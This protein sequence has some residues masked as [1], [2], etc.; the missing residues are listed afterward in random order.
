MVVSAVEIISLS[1]TRGS[2]K[3]KI[4]NQGS[5]DHLFLMP[6]ELLWLSVSHLVKP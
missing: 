2:K 6:E 5:A 3:I 4:Q 1:K